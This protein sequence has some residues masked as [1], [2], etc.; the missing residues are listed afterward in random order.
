MLLFSQLL[1]E[2]LIRSVFVVT[3]ISRVRTQ[4]ASLGLRAMIRRQSTALPPALWV[5]LWKEYFSLILLQLCLVLG[6]QLPG[7][8]NLLVSTIT[9]PGKSAPKEAPAGIPRNVDGLGRADRSGDWPDLAE[10]VEVT[11]EIDRNPKAGVET[12]D[13]PEVRAAGAET[14]SRR[15][16]ETIAEERI[17]ILTSSSIIVFLTNEINWV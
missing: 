5:L 13:E 15:T 4:L 2:W 8:P 14:V 11:E 3:T 9:A 10:K 12:S 7:W 1:N 16:K 17:D 6:F